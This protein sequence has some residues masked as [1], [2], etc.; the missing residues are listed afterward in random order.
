MRYILGCL[1]MYALLA[2]AAAPAQAADPV[3]VC[4]HDWPPFY[5]AGAEDKPAGL[6]RDLLERCLP[7]M[8]QGC[9]Y[10]HFPIAR[11]FQ[12]ME[13]GAAD[14]TVFSYKEEREEFVQY[15]KESLFTVAYRPVVRAGG[16]V[17][18]RS[19]AD[20]DGLKLGH[21]HGLRYSKEYKAYLDQRKEQGGVT[22]AY[23]ADQLLRMLDKGAID[24]FVDS[25]QSIAWE[26]MALDMRDRIRFEDFDVQT[27]DYFVAVSRKT[28]RIADIDS[29]L[30]Q[31]DACLKQVKQNGV[32]EQLMIGYGYVPP[33]E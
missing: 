8:D 28:P 21:L 16:D 10:I 29:F 30:L 15:G 22:T 2:L 31:T 33:K 27:K 24:V 6:G 26:A 23:S 19:L 3:I 7:A 25:R 4:D 14:V 32:Y 18:I 5:F 12:N 11:M 13:T 17:V 9:Q 1:L 20:F